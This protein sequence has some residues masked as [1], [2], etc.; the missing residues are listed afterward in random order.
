[1]EGFESAH[2]LNEDVPNFLFLDVGL[3]LL[4]AADLLED[5]AIVGV[6]HHQAVKTKCNLLGYCGLM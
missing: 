2:D 1:V 5:V 3:S 4:V 6:L